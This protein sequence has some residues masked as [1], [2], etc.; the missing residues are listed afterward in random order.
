MNACLDLQITEFVTVNWLALTKAIDCLGGVTVH[1]EEDEIQV[2][3]QYIA[4][5]VTVTGIY[6]D[7]VFATGN[8]LL[9]GTQATA[10]ARI[11]S[12]DR[13]DI[14]RTERQRDV[15]TKMIN[16][17]KG[18][19]MS[20][21]ED[22][23]DEVFPNVYTSITQDEMYSYVKGIFSYK[24]DETVGFPFAYMPVNHAYKGSVLV[25]ANLEA[26]V[27]ALHLFLFGTENYEPTQTVKDISAKLEAET[28]VYEQEISIDTYTAE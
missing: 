21:I 12:T 14:T 3:N 11:R 23:I 13:G 26:N 10:Y 9:N 24:L 16:K 1:I 7:G 25:P 28:G 22:I 15:L 19:D 4:G 20:T 2:L 5:Q 18:T 8:Q 27:S 6:S 17:A